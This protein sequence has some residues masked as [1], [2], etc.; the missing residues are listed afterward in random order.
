MYR[1]MKIFTLRALAC[2]NSPI[3]SSIFVSLIKRLG[4]KGK[5]LLCSVGQPSRNFVRLLRGN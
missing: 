3:A 4:E 1:Y 5:K 2:M